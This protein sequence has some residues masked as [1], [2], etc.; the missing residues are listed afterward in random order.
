MGGVGWPDFIGMVKGKGQFFGIEAKVEGRKPTLNQIAI[1]K[2]IEENGGLS[3]LAYSLDDVQ[4]AG[5]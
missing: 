2:Q 5:L 3:V 1:L 4:K